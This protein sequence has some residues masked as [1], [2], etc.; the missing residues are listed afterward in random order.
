MAEF[1]KHAKTSV[2]WDIENCGISKGA[3][4][5]QVVSGTISMLKGIHV[6]S[7]ISIDIY[8]NIKSK[9]VSGLKNSL[10]TVNH[11]PPNPLDNKNKKY[12]ADKLIITNMFK[13]AMHNSLPANLVLVSSDGDFYYTIHN[14]GGHGYCIIIVKPKQAAKL[15][16]LY[17]LCFIME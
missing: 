13:W 3:E 12:S 15:L 16:T 17:E 11:I 9:I 14:L 2:W 1:N 6:T 7:D 5:E 8:G 10:I 4:P